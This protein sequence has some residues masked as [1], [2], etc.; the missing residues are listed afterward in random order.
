MA[1]TLTELTQHE[2][3]GAA[4]SDPLFL[5]GAGTRVERLGR[6]SSI[7]GPPAT[8]LRVGQLSCRASIASC[9]TGTIS[10]PRGWKSVG[11]SQ[12]VPGNEVS[13]LDTVLARRRRAEALWPRP[14]TATTDAHRQTVQTRLADIDAWKRRS[15][16]R[17][18]LKG[19]GFTD[20]EKADALL[21]F[22][23]GCGCVVAL[24]AVLFSET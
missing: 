23:G 24:A 13:L 11:V 19:W 20:E 8:T 15:R 1:D 12:E 21:A 2:S 17:T 7:V 3:A 22:S 16:A 9:D 6:R 10:L 5:D 14:K 4:S 18:I